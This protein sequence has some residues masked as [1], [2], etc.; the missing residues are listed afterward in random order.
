MATIEVTFGRALKIW[1]SFLWRATVLMIPVMV[2]AM[3]IS[4]AI[5]PFP[6]PGQPAAT[7]QPDQLPAMMGKAFFLWLFMMSF[8]IAMQVQAIRW[9]LKTKWRGFRLQVVSDDN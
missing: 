6:K 2:V 8:N 5:F 1:W 7:L 4:I 9:M 3:I